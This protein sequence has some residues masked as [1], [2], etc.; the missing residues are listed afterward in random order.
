MNV[1]CCFFVDFYDKKYLFTKCMIHKDVCI[2]NIQSQRLVNESAM[3][4]NEN[5]VLI[6]DCKSVWILQVTIKYQGEMI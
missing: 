2:Q 6:R 3:W 4:F 1:I 5:C